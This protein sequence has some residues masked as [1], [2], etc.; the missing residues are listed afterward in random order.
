MTTNEKAWTRFV[1]LR[2]SLGVL[3]A[4]FPII[5]VVVA[6]LDRHPPLYYLRAAVALGYLGAVVLTQSR[7]N[8][9]PCPRCGR[10][11]FGGWR[12][13][14][15]PLVWFSLSSRKC[16]HCGLSGHD[17]RQYPSVPA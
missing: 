12:A 4:A 15:N 17:A 11:Y 6:V 7:L 8:S 9:W 16:V 3:Y 5:I 14:Y 2:T 13:A 10:H 1:R